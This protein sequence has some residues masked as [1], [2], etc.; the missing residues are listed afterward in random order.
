MASL[1]VS[2]VEDDTDRAS[3]GR[4]EVERVEEDV[5]KQR[6]AHELRTLIDTANAPIFGI[7]K[8]GMVNEWNYSAADIVGYTAVEVM[9]R[10]LVGEFISPEYKQ[11]VKEVLDNALQGKETANF[12][13]P[14]FTKDHKRVEMLLNATSR[15]D[16]AGNVV[17][18]VG[19]GQD[20]TERKQVEL[21]K[22]L[23]AHDL[24]TLIDTANAPIFGIDKV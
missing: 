12:E 7:D 16:E 21:E 3:N 2:D 19:V 1:D 11:L 24:R 8:D 23:V 13:L 17:G 15:R 6:V 4:D 10:D 20:I 18:V 5:A 22:E 9:G 14:I